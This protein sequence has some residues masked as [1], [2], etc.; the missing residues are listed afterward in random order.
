MSLV[1]DGRDVRRVSRIQEQW[2]QRFKP[3][4]PPRPSDANK[5][6]QARIVECVLENKTN[7]DYEPGSPS[8]D[9]ALNG[10]FS[11]KDVKL[12]RD[13]SELNKSPSDDDVLNEM[14]KRGGQTLLLSLTI[15]INLLWILEVTPLI[16]KTVV[17]KPMYKKGSL[18]DPLNYRPIALLSNLFKLYERVIDKRIRAV[19]LIALEQCGFRPG[20]ST[21]VA[22]LRLSLL[23]QHQSASGGELWLAFLDLEQAFERAWRMGILYQLWAAGVRGKCWR[24]ITEMLTGISAFVARTTGTL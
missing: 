15:F 11:V 1:V 8:Y 16:W 4:L 5:N 9:P 19:I 23:I 20:F 10:P 14:L 12:A 21:E 13:K 3:T 2:V 17:M 18:L 7:S 24:V 6:F 22:L